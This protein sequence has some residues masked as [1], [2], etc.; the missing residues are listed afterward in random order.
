M[1]Q[2]RAIQQV[3]ADRVSTFGNFSAPA[4]PGI[5]GLGLIGTI[6]V[7][8]GMMLAAL[9]L[10][11]S[12]YAALGIGGATLLVLGLL[13][14]RHQDRNLGQRL[15]RR[16]AWMRARRGRQHVYRSGITAPV[17][18]LSHR[19]PG[20]AAASR[21]HTGLD[22]YQREFAL[23][24]HPHVGHFGVVLRC[25]PDGAALVDQA[26][27]ETQV[28]GY[29]EFLAALADEPGIVAATVTVESAPDPGIR[30]A[31]E[32]NR[33]TRPAAPPVAR[34]MMREIGQMYRG[35]GSALRVTAVVVYSPAVIRG[36]GPRQRRG[37]WGGKRRRI[38]QVR[39]ELG[40]RVPPLC[41]L[42]AAAGG[43]AVAPLAPIELAEL[44]RGA[45]DPAAE[46]YIARARLTAEGSGV[47]WGNAGPVAAQAGWSWYRHDSGISRTWTMW[48]APR[49][50][51][52]STVLQ[53]LLEAHKDIPRKRVTLIYRPYP[54]SETITEVERDLRDAMF[55]HAEGS[56]VSARAEQRV[57]AAKQ[58]ADE[59]AR[60]A[61]LER[62]SMLVTVTAPNLKVL[63][64]AATTLE[65]RSGRVRL[66]P[67]FAAQDSAFAASLPIGVILPYY[68]A[69]PALLRD[70]L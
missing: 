32:I 62:F 16:G 14:F 55:A 44:V 57:R 8:G 25:E 21:L 34:T 60:G 15:V 54:V 48:D 53:R 27:V 26:T 38:E 70:A 6:V 42:L 36:D 52:Q 66:R 18:A 33:L 24:E 37:A 49:G 45:Y 58:T 40:A 9:A 59:E 17:P 22:P 10:A 3:P 61:G 68:A 67:C 1:T 30:L 31:A 41:E 12:F 65:R 51:V 19:L 43:G 64:F 63:E 20:L 56:G 4:R 46:D 5:W 50:H 11:V 23:V 2:P 28:A 35:G 39:L 13:A 69:A 29:A 7:V 47:D